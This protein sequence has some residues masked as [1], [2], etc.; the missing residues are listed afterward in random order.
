MEC[1]VVFVYGALVGT[2]LSA[3]I[4]RMPMKQ[5]VTMGRVHCSVCNMKVGMMS[6][7]PIV[8][9]LLS[10]GVCENCNA[11]LRRQ[12]LFVE[13]LTAT[14]SILIYLETGFSFEAVFFMLLLYCL[15]VVA[16][17]D[18]K[19][20]MIPNQLIW[21]MLSLGLLFTF[22]DLVANFNDVSTHIVGMTVISLPLLFFAIFAKGSIGMGDVKLF[23]VAGLFLGTELVIV[24][25]VISIIIAGLVRVLFGNINQRSKMPF[26]PYVCAG[27][28]VSMLYGNEIVNA[29]SRSCS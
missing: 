29:V 6:R 14:L 27:I 3:Y 4:T 9:Y 7:I 2:L 18:Y 17:I 11:K 10:G 15:I 20:M 26:A 12:N 21:S 1:F 5:K 22:Y 19:Y 16:M 28:Y 24:A 8:G 13:L 23:A 25:F